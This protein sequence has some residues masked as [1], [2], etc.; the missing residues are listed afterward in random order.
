[1]QMKQKDSYFLILAAVV[2]ALGGLLFGFD[3]AVISGT[4]PFIQPYFHLN[5]ISLG[6]TVSSLLAGCIVGVISAGK[7][8]D[9]FGR[10]KTLMAAAALFLLSALGSAL[11]HVH[12]VFI[13]FRV[14]GGFAVGVASM[15]SPMYISEISPAS[16]RGQLVTLNQMAIVLGIMLAFF[17]NY[18]L[19]GTGINNWRWMFAIMGV[20]ALLFLVSLI[21]VPESPRWLAQKGME[22][23]AFRILSRINGQDQA[24]IELADIRNSVH[25]EKGT[26]KEVFSPKMKPVMLLGVLLAVFS[27]VTGINSIM[28]YAPVIFQ[29]T[30]IGTDSALLQ[31][32]TIGSVN[33][34]FTLVA[35]AWVDRLGRKP[36]LIGGTIGMAISLTA[37]TLA[38]YTQKFSG[39]IIL[40]FILIYIA[41]FAASLGPVTWVVVSEIFPNKLR[42]KAMSVAIVALWLANFIVILAFPVVL[43]RLGG[44][45][46]FLIFD[47]MC[48]VLI[49]FIF[50]KV[51]ETKGKSLEDLE[52]ILVRH[53]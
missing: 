35:I 12:A 36:L 3:T 27:Q 45:T 39:F 1:M 11:S 29:K 44:A 37:L 38:F 6:W 13:I 24:E 33:V 50:I 41:S 7:P 18:W 10:K 20:P 46:A 19:S 42:S 43:N 23:E 5:D 48:I 47:L 4:I 22:T 28:Y 15:L 26:Y 51:P 40:G 17:S 53:S 2:A 32:A 30:G 16:K 8:G 14:I 49:L 34:L 9:V 25:A 31:T 52:K 21:F